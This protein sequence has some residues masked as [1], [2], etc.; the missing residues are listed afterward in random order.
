MHFM[1]LKENIS[2]NDLG[3]IGKEAT[4]DP[5]SVGDDDNGIIY[6]VDSQHLNQLH[7]LEQLGQIKLIKTQINEIENVDDI[8]QLTQTVSMLQGGKLKLSVSI[9][10]HRFEFDEGELLTGRALRMRLLRL[11]TYIKIKQEEWDALIKN[12]L[13]IAEEVD[14]IGEEDELCEDILG[15]LRDCIIYKERDKTLGKYTLWSNQENENVVY[16]YSENLRT[17]RNE[18]FSLRKLR[19]LM[20]GFLAGSSE[21]IRVS[22]AKKRFWP[23][24]IDK[25]D[26]DIKKQLFS[27][28]L[29]EEGAT[30]TK[31]LTDFEDSVATIE[32]RDLIFKYVDEITEKDDRG[33]ML[34]VLEKRIDTTSPYSEE[35]AE[36]EAKQMVEEGLLLKTKGS[37]GFEFLLRAKETE[38][39]T[40]PGRD[41]ARSIRE[42][43][44][45]LEKKKG[46][47]IQMDEVLDAAEEEGIGRDKAEEIIEVM[48]RDGLLYSPGSGVIK[49]VR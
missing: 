42:I 32:L 40:K 48:K 19:W 35:E 44:K 10:N 30:E 21:E 27:E 13:Q 12:W 25:C 6:S 37:E 45:E 22:G 24:L 16:C 43:I 17:L 39:K 9:A 8:L 49:F 15:Y 4:L 28:E 31:E 47:E 7:I 1:I 34:V 23:F 14:E 36:E 29:E 5:L 26:I 11:R 46:E 18:E 20:D 3:D 41:R 2:L 38:G 33:A